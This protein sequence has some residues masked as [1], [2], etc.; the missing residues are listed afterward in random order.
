MK[1]KVNN[2]GQYQCVHCSLNGQCTLTSISIGQDGKCILFK[3][4]EEFIDDV[5]FDPI[6]EHTNMC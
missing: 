4:K 3:S 1:T 2:C 5:Y 6:D